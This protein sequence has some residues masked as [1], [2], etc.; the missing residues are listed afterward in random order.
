MELSGQAVFLTGGARGI[1][2][3][4]V[5]ALLEKGAKVLFCDVRAEAGKAAET[6]LRQ[7]FGADR[8]FFQECDVADGESLK[9]AFDAAVSQFGAVDICINNAAILNESAWEKTIQINLNGLIRGTQLAMEHMRR[10][11]GGRGGLIINVGSNLGFSP[12]HWA[13]VY[14]ATKHAVI[15]FTASWAKNPKTREMGI[16]WKCFCPNATDTPIVQ[17]QEGMV[18]ELEEFQREVPK[19]FMRVEDTVAEF[20][21]VAQ[22]QDIDEVTYYVNKDGASR[23]VRRQ[24]VDSDGFSNPVTVDNLLPAPDKNETEG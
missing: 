19:V 15:G 3:G 10:D 4:V 14:V 9:A 13:P 17:V 5:E 6:E 24:L 23:Y 22:D 16:R 7:K 18:H 8:V 20:M 2:R 1:G 11:R 21:K 12:S